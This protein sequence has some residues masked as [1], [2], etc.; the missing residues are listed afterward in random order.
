MTISTIPENPTRDQY[1]Y[2]TKLAEQTERYEEMVNFIEELLVGKALAGKPTVEE[3]NLLSVAY[4]NVIGSLQVT[5]Y[6]VSSIKQK[7][8]SRKN[9]DHVV[10]VKDYRSK[11]ILRTNDLNTATASTIRRALEHEFGIDLSNCK[12]FIRDQIDLYLGS[13]LDDTDVGANVDDNDEEEVDE[14]EPK[15]TQP[16]S[17]VKAF[18]APLDPLNPLG[19]LETVF[20]FVSRE[21]EL[22]KGDFVVRRRCVGSNL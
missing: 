13:Q 12:L 6:I 17:S 10:L 5:W 20:D 15:L 21:F 19:F 4:K 3:R 9:K 11:E 22:F 18:N 1:L 7:E 2:M 16:S 8:E 14:E